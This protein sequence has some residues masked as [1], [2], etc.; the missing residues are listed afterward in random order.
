M[1][2]WHARQA[3]Y[4]TPNMAPNPVPVWPFVVGG[5]A[6]AGLGGAAYC[7]RRTYREQAIPVLDASGSEPTIKSG[8]A[9]AEYRGCLSGPNPYR[10][11]LLVD[12]NYPVDETFFSTKKAALEAFDAAVKSKDSE[13]KSEN[14]F[15]GLIVGALAVGAAAAGYAYCRHTVVMEETREFEP[16]QAGVHAHTYTRILRYNGCL[17][18]LEPYEV[19]IFTQTDGYAKDD[20]KKL[21]ARLFRKFKDQKSAQE[22]YESLDPIFETDDVMGDPE[23]RQLLMSIGFAATVIH[24]DLSGQPKERPP[25]P[26]PGGQG[27]EEPPP[28]GPIDGQQEN[29]I[30][31][32]LSGGCDQCISRGMCCDPRDWGCFKCD[33]PSIR[34]R[35][36]RPPRRRGANPATP[37]LTRDKVRMMVQEWGTAVDRF[38][39]QARVWAQQ[40]QDEID[41]AYRAGWQDG[42]RGMY[43]PR[44]IQDFYDAGYADGAPWWA[45]SGF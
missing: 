6:A 5:V 43:R 14:P 40:A 33:T 36:G 25:A 10:V 37:D 29:P 20:A 12:D 2:P 41:A 24:N 35:P 3:F 34:R 42:A 45:Q 27:S 15:G 18:G 44:G 30:N 1:H 7:S 8:R 28:M 11:A 19:E 26:R 21:K 4:G 31:T 9:V 13:E 22:Y 39:G 23:A 32:Q 38:A 16:G 17:S